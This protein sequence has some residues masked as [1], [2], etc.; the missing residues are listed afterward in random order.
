MENLEVRAKS[1]FIK[2]INAPDNSTIKWEV[3]PMKRSINFGIYRYKNDKTISNNSSNDQ[4]TNTLNSL[5]NTNKSH[6]SSSSSIPTNSTPVLNKKLNN[7]TH[8]LSLDE[9]NELPKKIFDSLQKNPS[10]NTTNNNSNNN[11]NDNDSANRNHE[12]SKKE[13]FNGGLP[14]L[15]NNNS[16]INNQHNF[17]QHSHSDL[18]DRMDKHLV[19]EQ[20]IGRCQ[21]DELITGAFT[22][23]TGGL[24]AFVFDNTFSRTKGKKIMFNQYIESFEDDTDS[25]ITSSNNNNQDITAN[26]QQR[27]GNTSDIPAP[28]PVISTTP[29]P[30]NH[31]HRMRTSHTQIQMHL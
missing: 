6:S 7:S 21:G 12:I 16:P 8:K 11:N 9:V 10:D 13:S 2:W 26:T 19:K 29:L 27:K 30:Q 17:H 5:S 25:I 28:S 20:W 22:V 1:F 18:E 14:R 24:Y 31:S 23:N 4:S 15:N 3:K